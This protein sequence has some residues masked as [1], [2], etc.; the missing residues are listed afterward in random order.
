M[1]MF[2]AVQK[3]FGS[4]LCNARHGG[5]LLLIQ[6]CLNMKVLESS[7]SGLE[8]D[9]LLEH[10]EYMATPVFVHTNAKNGYLQWAYLLYLL[11]CIHAREVAMAVQRKMVDSQCK[12][13][14]GW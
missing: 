7:S 9:K 8:K 4:P 6:K 14:K 10:E 3:K 5:S 2:A 13:S 12:K 1:F 11:Q